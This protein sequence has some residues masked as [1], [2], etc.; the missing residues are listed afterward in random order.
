MVEFNEGLE[1]SACRNSIVYNDRA[2]FCNVMFVRTLRRLLLHRVKE[3]R[4]ILHK[5]KRRKANWIG[6]ILCRNYLLKQVI[7]GTIEGNIEDRRRR[8]RSH[9]QLLDDLH[10][11]R[12][13]CNLKGRILD[14]ALWRN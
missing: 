4:N 6:R 5:M 11:K 1:Y 8:G 10:E 9:K 2:V 3:E 14:C 7:E 12:K 13:Y